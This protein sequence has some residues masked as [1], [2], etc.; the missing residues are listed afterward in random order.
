MPFERYR[1]R[2]ILYGCGDLINDYEGIEVRDG[3]R[4]DVGCPYFV[5]LQSTTGALQRL[6]IVALQLRRFRLR[7]A[8]AAARQWAMRWLRPDKAAGAS[9]SSTHWCLIR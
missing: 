4:S 5:T 3:W 1:D 7:R 6:E 2:L 8:D 9:L